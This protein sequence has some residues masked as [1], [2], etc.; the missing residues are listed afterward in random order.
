MWDGEETSCVH[1]LSDEWNC[2]F[3]DAD[4]WSWWYEQAAEVM[5]P[6]IVDEECPG[7]RGHL[8]KTDSKHNRGKQC[9]YPYTS[10][11]VWGCPACKKRLPQWH[12]N[13]T[14]DEECNALAKSIRNEIQRGLRG[15]YRPR[16]QQHK[17]ITSREGAPRVTDARAGDT[18][19]E[20][21]PPRTPL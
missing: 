10:P 9:K 15:A 18:S 11:E 16:L 21:T 6:S 5:L 14:W 17:S 2:W 7:C 8:S 4:P 1:E 20:Q 19:A 3:H 13:H 12:P